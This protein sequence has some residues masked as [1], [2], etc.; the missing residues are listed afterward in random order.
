MPGGVLCVT[1]GLLDIL[2]NEAELAAILGHEIGHVERSHLFD[3][4][5]GEMLSRKMGEPTRSTSLADLIHRML[6]FS[7]SKTQEDEA[8]EYAFR[9]LVKMG[10]DPY[11]LSRSFER[12]MEAEH[13]LHL[14]GHLITDFFSSHPC[15]EHRIEKFRSK[16]K[17][18]EEHHLIKDLYI[19][20]KNFADRITFF[21]TQFSDEWKTF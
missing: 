17:L 4:L 21:E 19:G 8:D 18:W 16:A 7:Y 2:E 3:A 5:R 6:S 11:A 10:Y 1:K 9:L 14:S 13:R 20:K 15:T 12:L